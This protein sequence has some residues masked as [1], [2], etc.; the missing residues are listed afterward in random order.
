MALDYR[1]YG[2]VIFVEGS[3]D[4][5]DWKRNLFC[6][7][8]RGWAGIGRVN[9]I[10]RKE[11]R[12]LLRE[13]RCLPNTVTLIGYSRGGAIAQI[14]AAALAEKGR[15]VD[16]ILFASKRTGNEAF[17][18][19]LDAPNI[20]EVTAKR[21][22]GDIV[23]FLPPWYANVKHEAIGDWQVPWKAHTGYRWKEHT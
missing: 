6:L 12:K 3:N 17:V 10:D 22:R 13:N 7:R 21:K 11:A 18:K 5:P 19:K 23:P 4:Y 20:A 16:L 15:A 9:R 8:R 1:R 14:A 2:G